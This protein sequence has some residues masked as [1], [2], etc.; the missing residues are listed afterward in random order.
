MSTPSILE[1]EKTLRALLDGLRNAHLAIARGDGSSAIAYADEADRAA[2][3]LDVLVR[4]NPE[5]QMA[6]ARL[7]IAILAGGIAALKALLQEVEGKRAGPDEI[8][9]F[10]LRPLPATLSLARDAK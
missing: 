6:A 9:A 2:N 4:A 3:R 5:H 1:I 10:L 8:T 7:F